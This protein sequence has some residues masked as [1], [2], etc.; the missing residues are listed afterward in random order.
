[1]KE[2]LCQA[3]A[4]R[5]LQRALASQK[6]AHSYIFYGPYGVGKSTTAQQWGKLLLCKNKIAEPAKA[7]PFYESCGAC[8]SCK[9]F[10]VGTHPD[11]QLVYKELVQYTRDGKG[12]KTPVA[13]PIDV[14]REF[15]IEKVAAR[16]IL[17]ENRVFVVREAEKLNIASQNSLLKVLEEPPKGSFFILICTQLEK[18]LPTIRSRCQIIRFVSINEEKIIEKLEQMDIEKEQ[19]RYWAR[20]SEGSLGAAMAWTQLKSAGLDCYE[21]KKELVRKLAKLKLADA[22][23]SAKWILIQSKKIAEAWAKQE[24]S[25]SQADINRSVQ[26][27]LVQMVAAAFGDAMKINVGLRD[28]LINFD[29]SN[30]VRKLAKKFDAETAAEKVAGAYKT[31]GWIDASVNE[32]LTFAG[33]L[34]NC[35]SSDKI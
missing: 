14:I 17:S 18:L 4:V 24:K 19:A 34:L 30:E 20:F 27:G 35:T 33:L 22:L 6:I 25:K 2:I 13:L 3:N 9:A 5:A 16:P 11:F 28:K 10:Q 15:L 31:M 23:E 8:E 12:K 7:G 29:Q 26:K 32:N 21:I 1:M